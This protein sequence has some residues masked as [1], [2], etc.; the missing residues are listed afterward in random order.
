MTLE[1][2]GFAAAF[3]VIGQRNRVPHGWLGVADEELPKPPE[4]P[5]DDDEPPPHATSAQPR[6]KIR[7]AHSMRLPFVKN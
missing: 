4:L 3:F 1:V 6:K 5:L 7:A 2:S